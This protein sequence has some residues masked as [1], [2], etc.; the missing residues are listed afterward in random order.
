MKIILITLSLSL[1]A[2]FYSVAQEQESGLKHVGK[3]KSMR[4]APSLSSR[5]TLN[6]AIRRTEEPKDG[7]YSKVRRSRGNLVPKKDP[8]VENDYLAAN[9][10]RLDKKIRS[11]NLE[12]DFIVNNNTFSPSDPALAVGTNHVFIVYNTGFNIYDKNGNDLTGEL[13]VDNIFSPGGCCDLT[14]SYDNAADR[15]VLTYLFFDGGI[16]VAVSDGPDPLTANW[17]VYQITQGEDYNKLSIWRDGYYITDNSDDVDVW[18]LDRDAAIAG[19]PSASIQGFDIPDVDGVNFTGAQ[20][21]NVIDDNMPTTGGAPYVFLRDDGFDNVPQDQ[22]NIWT[23][24]VDFATPANSNVSAPE[25]FVVTP[26]INVFDGGSFS[27]LEQP[28]GQNID[29]LQSTIMNQAQFRKFPT[30]NSA[31]FNFVVD[32]DGGS[33]ELAGIR[34]YEFRQ[35]GDGQP[36]TMFQ[37]G[38]YTAPE[39]KHA[40]MGS[41]AIDSEG[42]IALG[43]S[44]MAGP[45]TL[46]P[47]D[48]RVGTFYTGRFALDPPGV[49]TIAE[50]EIGIGAGDIE[51]ER[52]GDYAKMDVDPSNGEDFWFISEYLNTDHVA[53]F[54][55][56]PEFDNDIGVINVDSPT[57]GD[58]SDLQDITVTIFNFG[59]EEASGFNVTYQ[60]DGGALVT[61][62]FT[63]SIASSTSEQFTFSTQADLSVVGQSYV[64]TTCTDYGIDQNNDND[65][66]SQDVI[67][68][69]PNNVGVTSIS[70]VTFSTTQQLTIEISNFGAATQTSIPV[71]YTLNGGS[72]VTE[73]YT[74]SLAQGAIDTYTF[75]ATEDLSNMGEYVFIAGTELVGD[76]DTSNDDTTRTFINALCIPES[77]ASCIDEGVIGLQLADQDITPFCNDNDLGYNDDTDI[78]FNF[79]LNDNPFQGSLEIGFI[80]TQYALWI[81]FNDNNN[82]EDDELILS[83]IAPTDNA[84]I[85][86]TID[87]STIPTVTNG[88]HRMRLRSEGGFGEPLEACNELLFGKTNDYTANITGILGIEDEAFSEAELLILYLPENQYEIIFNTVEYTN[89]L[90]ITIYNTLGQKLAY[91]TVE[92]NGTGY[93]KIINMSHVSSGIYFIQVGNSQL[94]RT[95]KIIVQ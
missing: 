23:I 29:A 85:D 74:G 62:A 10:G 49:M 46:N 56:I 50:Q 26:F 48:H 27:N 40:W 65:C 47:T 25:E 32:T 36:W 11:I 55:L 93:N 54:Q 8:Q 41:M 94:N 87:F 83:G 90:P 82:F 52:Y 92:N 42:N 16:E 67:H 80:D 24:N 18:V 61:E 88:M 75:T 31:V 59:L 9:P 69:N 12:N 7:R 5:A 6:P 15:W 95:R 60:I 76:S 44:S 19:D 33:E 13:S 72:A 39:G 78:I 28:D 84:N 17:F 2:T 4:I 70:D 91:Y 71:F 3:V 37:E 89:R 21:F 68:L 58:L 1:M 53:V 63:G 35:S 20:V 57:D 38:T 34:W 45:S 77:L 66:I 43:Y 30:H 22:V 51:G 14:A 86:F 73:T 81:D 64:I 79:I